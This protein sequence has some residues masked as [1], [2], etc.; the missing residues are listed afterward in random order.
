MKKF[1]RLNDG[2]AGC[3]VSGHSQGWNRWRPAHNHQSCELALFLL[4]VTF[5]QFGGAEG[6]D[7]RNGSG[8]D[9]DDKILPPVPVK[10]SVRHS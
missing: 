2:S 3:P 5:N 10:E 4:I 1:E 7:N 6:Q 8:K 9:G